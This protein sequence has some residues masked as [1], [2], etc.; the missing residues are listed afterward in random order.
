MFTEMYN[1]LATSAVLSIPDEQA[2]HFTLAPA[3]LLDDHRY[4]LPGGG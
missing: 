3:E 2:E 4:R 1:S